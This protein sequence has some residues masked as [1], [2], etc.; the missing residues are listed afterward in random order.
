[1][2]LGEHALCGHAQSGNSLNLE[3]ISI[4]AICSGNVPMLTKKVQ[5]NLSNSV[6]ILDMLVFKCPVDINSTKSAQ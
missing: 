2:F 3:N 6:L 1:M 4:I 5:L